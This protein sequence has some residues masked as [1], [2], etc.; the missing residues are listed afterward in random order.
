MATDCFSSTWQSVCMCFLEFI[1]NTHA[2]AGGKPFEL[3]MKYGSEVLMQVSA[4]L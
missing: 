3:F 1:G 2:G 4:L